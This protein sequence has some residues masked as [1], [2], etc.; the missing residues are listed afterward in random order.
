MLEEMQSARPRPRGTALTTVLVVA[1]LLATL[2]CTLAALTTSQ[3]QLTQRSNGQRVARNLAESIVSDAI[4]RLREN[5][6]FGGPRSPATITTSDDRENQGLLTFDPS[7]A[8]SLDIA[9]STYNIGVENATTGWNGSVVP[10]DCVQLIGTGRYHGIVHRVEAV[11]Y[12]PRFP[13][14]IACSGPLVSSG[15]FRVA[16]VRDKSAAPA[17]GLGDIADDNLAPGHVVTNASGL[18]DGDALDLQGEGNHVTGDVQ[19]CGD[20]RL[21]TDTKV[22]GQ[23]RPHADA[24]RLPRIDGRQYS[25]EG[26][27]GVVNLT[28]R[29]TG[30]GP[31]LVEGYANRSGNLVLTRG[32]KLDSG[33]LYVNGNLTVTGGVSGRGAVIVMGDTT[34]EGGGALETDSMAALISQGPIII[35]GEPGHKASFSGLMYTESS[36][37]A[38]NVTLV[39]TLITNARAGQTGAI[40]LVDTD[41][42][43]VPASLAVKFDVSQPS[44]PNFEQVY[45]V[46]GNAFI[47]TRRT[48]LASRGPHGHGGHGGHGGGDNE[49]EFRRQGSGHH[50]RDEESDHHENR[51]RSDANLQVHTGIVIINQIDLS[52]RR[53]AIGGGGD[54]TQGG[55]D[56]TSTQA[57]STTTSTSNSN[58]FGTADSDS[59]VNTGGT[60]APNDGGPCGG[61][62]IRV[63]A[64][65]KPAALEVIG[66]QGF[67]QEKM[68]EYVDV[69]IDGQSFSSAEALL[70]YLREQG[71]DPGQV[72]SDLYGHYYP[73]AAD[74]APKEQID[75]PPP[76]QQ[77]FA[78]DLSE[79]VGIEEKMRVLSWRDL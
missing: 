20:V 57:G 22:D 43:Q 53:R 73:M 61:R 77:P 21:S 59:K 5:R 31:L 67:R 51:R 47:F 24:V 3:L 16:A 60:Q 45:R 18:G 76:M 55:T 7:A 35:R 36:L 78:L 6:E 29:P 46:G 15:G 63:T 26:K 62:E 40:T 8:A 48:L 32:L 25:T 19:A 79:F 44:G 9:P 1:T 75:P 54:T 56:S 68:L 71:V 11:V 72:V 52:T 50:D 14:V 2:A 74:V 10:A 66:K 34:I 28:E 58:G 41:I 17:N 12:L 39:G 23:V 64:V 30:S 33:V 38:T 37:K 27:P 49:R 65:L 69:Q 13:Y 42:I 70:S 4:A